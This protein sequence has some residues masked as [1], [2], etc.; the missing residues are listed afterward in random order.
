MKKFYVYEW[1]NIENNEVFYVGKGC[2]KR[3]KALNGRNQLFIDYIKNNKVDSRIVI[4]NLTEEEAFQKEIELT[5]KYKEIGQCQCSLAA[6]GKGGCHF[7][8]TDKMRQYYS[9]HNGMK[10]EAQKERMKQNNPMKNKEYAMKNGKAHKT[11][12]IINGIEYEGLVDAAKVYNVSEVTI[13]N[14]CKKGKNPKGEECSYS[15]S[16][17]IN[18][19]KKVFVDNQIFPSISEAAIFIG[20]TPAAV[21]NAIAK[22]RPCKN[23]KCEYANQQPSQ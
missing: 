11:S 2:N 23:H 10:Q 14:W 7:V 19:G 1:F 4:D 20:V 22:N 15:K 3:Y 8:W 5:N 6:P 9:E 17:K 18:N 21:R 13:S 12:V 16:R